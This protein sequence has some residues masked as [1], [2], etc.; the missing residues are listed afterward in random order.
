M[1]GNEDGTS[2]DTNLGGKDFGDKLRD[3]F[4]D[5]FFAKINYGEFFDS[6]SKIC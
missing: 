6:T 2:G 5:N 4:L 1:C 3:Y